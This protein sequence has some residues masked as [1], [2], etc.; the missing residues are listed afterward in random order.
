MAEPLPPIGDQAVLFLWRVASVGAYVSMMR[1]RRQYRKAL[2]VRARRGAGSRAHAIY[3]GSGSFA[4]G[5]RDEDRGI[6]EGWMLRLEQEHSTGTRSAGDRRRALQH[7]P[8]PL[9]DRL[10][11]AH[12]LPRRPRV[13][14][15]GRA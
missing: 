8:A 9:R 14:D 1:D 5:Q 7:R 11:R 6:P 13:R 15:L 10:H 2:E 4:V 12:G 3:D